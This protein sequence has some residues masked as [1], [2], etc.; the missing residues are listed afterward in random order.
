M[1]RFPRKS[2]FLMLTT[3]LLVPANLFSAQ[4]P[5]SAAVRQREWLSGSG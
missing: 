2:R 1:I 5:Q 3:L 4:P